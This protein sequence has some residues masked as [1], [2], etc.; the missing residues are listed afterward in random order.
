[1]TRKNKKTVYFRRKREGRTDYKMRLRLLM[2]SMPRLIVRKSLKHMQIQLVSY[3]TSG[4]IVIVGAHTN[5]LK[6]F[7]WRFGSGNIP[8]AY[9]IG[10]LA[11]KKM[12]A[13]KIEETIL[14]IGLQAG[15]RRIYAVLKG[16]LDAG[17]KVPHD[18]KVIP[19]D[20]FIKGNHISNYYQS[21]TKESQEG[22]LQFS[23][24]IKNKS[25][26]SEMAA[27]IEK[28]KE[29]IDKK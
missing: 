1:M 16:V 3:K 10:Y 8:A 4:D 25:D 29:S 13:K 7:G 2:S 23:A 11:G 18:D 21:I 26:A 12:L 15:S 20:E 17:V 28:V 27:D 22:A 14:D 24:Y 6:K 5:E 9:L 19:G